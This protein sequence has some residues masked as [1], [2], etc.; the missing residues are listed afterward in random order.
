MKTLIL[1]IV[2][3]S[4]KLWAFAPNSDGR[5]DF[6]IVLG[7]DT[8]ASRYDNPFRF[9]CTLFMGKAFCDNTQIEIENE[10]CARTLFVDRIANKMEVSCM[11]KLRKVVIATTSQQALVKQNSS[12]Y[13][14]LPLR[15]TNAVSMKPSSK[16]TGYEIVV[17]STKSN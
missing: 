11:I 7:V 17:D 8:K 14:F 12:R 16:R 6:T 1:I 3:F 9:P 15:F 13:D 10:T 2:L 4:F 5:P